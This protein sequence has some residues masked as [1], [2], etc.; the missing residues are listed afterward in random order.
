MQLLGLGSAFPMCPRCKKR[1]NTGT[2]LN[3]CACP[4]PEPG[5]GIVDGPYN[6]LK[7]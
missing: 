5:V 6:A 3:G 7:R 2:L 1:R 4:P